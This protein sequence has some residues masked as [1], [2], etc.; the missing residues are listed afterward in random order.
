VRLNDSRLH[1]DRSIAPFFS[2]VI[3]SILYNCV[4]LTALIM[5]VLWPGQ[6][7]YHLILGSNIPIVFLVVFVSVLI[8]ISYIQMRCGRGELARNDYIAKFER[9]EIKTVEEETGF[10]SYTLVVAL[11]HTAFF[12][13]PV[14]PVLMASSTISGI[15]F[16]VFLKALG[17]LFIASFFCRIYG[18]MI[19]LIFGKWSTAGYLLCR[20]GY[21]VF[22]FVTGIYLSWFNPVLQIFYLYRGESPL[23]RSFLTQ[24]SLFNL[25]VIMTAGLI[26]LACSVMI[27]RRIIEK[28]NA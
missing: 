8:M 2:P 6:N 21:A 22:M 10:F 28:E 23:F 19:Y 14:L 18:F 26:F 7:G 3:M 27:Q 25:S 11:L 13:L 24:Y 17:I 15:P 4:W 20:T 1:S 5:L 9:K 16:T 12:L